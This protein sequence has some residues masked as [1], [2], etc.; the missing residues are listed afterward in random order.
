[1]L[2]AGYKYAGKGTNKRRQYVVFGRR[3][4]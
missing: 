3:I 4:I 1:M 2:N